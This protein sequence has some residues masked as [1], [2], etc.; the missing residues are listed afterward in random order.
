MIPPPL[1]PAPPAPHPNP[2]IVSQV[3]FCSFESF[4]TTADHHH[5][6]M[7]HLNCSILSLSLSFSSLSLSL[8]LLSL[9]RS[10]CSSP[11]CAHHTLSV[12]PSLCLSLSLY[13][14]LSLSVPLSISLSLFLPLCVSL[15]PVSVSK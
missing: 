2:F 13:L 7:P 12:P 6:R 15:G 4:M 5:E 11:F 9:P 3:D 14:S 1:I 10:L 8:S